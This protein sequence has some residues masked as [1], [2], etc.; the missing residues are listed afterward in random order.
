M[1][2]RVG[3]KNVFKFQTCH[4][5]ASS[6]LGLQ[7]LCRLVTPWHFPSSQAHFRNWGTCSR[8][9]EV[10]ECQW[11]PSCFQPFCSESRDWTGGWNGWTCLGIVLLA[12][13]ESKHNLNNLCMSIR[14]VVGGRRVADWPLATL[15][16]DARGPYITPRRNRALPACR[17]SSPGHIRGAF[18]QLS[19]PSGP[20]QML[21]EK[22]KSRR[23]GPR[24]MLREK[25]KS[26]TS[27]Y[28]AS[29]ESFSRT[30]RLSESGTISVCLAALSYVH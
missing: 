12:Y 6:G 10:G 24:Q 28:D 11:L 8:P 18:G 30:P 2:L 25:Q 7:E 16:L 4:L 13:F 21:E 19:C 27:M 20:R 3:F 17:Q 5:F 29:P 26:R 9:W 15:E 14:G 22:Q 1:L 23:S